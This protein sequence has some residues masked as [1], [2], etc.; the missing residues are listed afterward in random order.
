LGLIEAIRRALFNLADKYIS[1]DDGSADEL[2]GQLGIFTSARL[3]GF[4]GSKWQRLRCDE[5]KHL[6]TGKSAIL[7]PDWVEEVVG[8]TD[9]VIVTIDNAYKYRA[10]RLE[11]IHVDNDFELN[12]F[13]QIVSGYWSVYGIGT[14]TASIAKNIDLSNTVVKKLF[15][16]ARASTTGGT[17][18]VKLAY[19][20]VKR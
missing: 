18:T 15:I 14:V 10:L 4:D 1:V 16:K 7:S 20:L 3:L 19:A 9:T 17:A 5:D 12:V 2:S 8:D 13:G 6:L 11:V